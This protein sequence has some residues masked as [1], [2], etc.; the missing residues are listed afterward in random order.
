MDDRV[1]D[2]RLTAVVPEVAP[3]VMLQPVDAA[4]SGY[5]A[6]YV[7][8]R[9]ASLHQRCFTDGWRDTACRQ[10]LGLPTVQVAF[11]LVP[12]TEIDRAIGFIVTQHAAFEMEILS[13]GVIPEMRN[14]K[15]ARTILSE[16]L[17]AARSARIK[18]VYLEVSERNPVAMRLYRNLSFSTVGR[19]KGY[20]RMPDGQVADALIYKYAL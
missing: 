13:V 4:S 1:G 5:D 20:Y 2:S 8:T 19:R 10:L 16:T 18:A 11:A 3:Q 15:I 9:L 14:R 12:A 17:T 6:A 7:A